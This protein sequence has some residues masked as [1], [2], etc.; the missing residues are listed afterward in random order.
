MGNFGAISAGIRS[1]PNDPQQASDSNFQRNRE[2]LSVDAEPDHLS[3]YLR[4]TLTSCGT[5]GGLLNFFLPW[6]SP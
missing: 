3:S 1:A 6:F 2:R 5:L 4:L